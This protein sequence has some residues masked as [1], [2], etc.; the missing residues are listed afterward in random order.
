MPSGAAGARRGGLRA[1][2]RC[3]QSHRD[4]EPAAGA[5]GEGEGPVVRLCDALDD[6]EAEADASVVGACAFSA[7]KK[8]LDESRD[9]LWGERL[10]GVLDREQHAVGLNACRD[11]HDAP[12]WQVVDDRVADEVRGKLPSA[13]T[14]TSNTANC[15]RVSAT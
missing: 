9:R 5:G 4:A 3:G 2:R 15:L 8:G 13:S 12:V 1:P 10:A 7:A 14:R 11:L 6:R